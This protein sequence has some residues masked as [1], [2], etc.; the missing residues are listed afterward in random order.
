MQQ[1]KALFLLW[2]GIL[3]IFI[4]CHSAKPTGRSSGKSQAVPKD[5]ATKKIDDGPSEFFQ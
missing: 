1:K 5:S 2:T 4:G 3:M